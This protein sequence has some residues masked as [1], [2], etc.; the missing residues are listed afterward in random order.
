MPLLAIW[1]GSLFTS[2]AGFFSLWFTKKVALLLVAITASVALVYSLNS[3]LAGFLAQIS[4]TVPS[5]LLIASSWIVPQ[6]FNWCVSA[7]IG[8]QVIRFAYD[9]QVRI[10]GWKVSG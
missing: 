9:W 4:Y 8:A 5:Y 10:L 3:A 7:V 1:L 6:N 2:F